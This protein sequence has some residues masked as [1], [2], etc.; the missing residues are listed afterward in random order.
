MST[1]ADY[2]PMPQHLEHELRSITGIV[3][4]TPHDG[5]ELVFAL[6]Q[7]LGRAYRDGHQAGRQQAYSVRY[8]ADDVT[9]AKDA[10]PEDS[11]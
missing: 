4:N 2:A 7:A 8:I 1:M 10:R 3:K 9:K 6:T 5:D 11:Q